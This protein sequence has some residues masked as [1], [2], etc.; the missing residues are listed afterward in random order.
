MPK[1]LRNYPI[2]IA[3]Q[4]RGYIDTT[5]RPIVFDEKTN[6]N[7]N[8]DDVNDKITIY[9]RQVK[10][11]F[12]N[13]ASKFL[14]GDNNG[15]I[16]LMLSIA[17]IEGVEQYMRGESSET[18]R[19]QRG[20]SKEF[21]REGMRRIFNLRETDEILNDFYSQVRCGLF[22]TGM[23][24]NKVIINRTFQEPINFSEQDT[25]KI[26]PKMFLSQVRIDFNAYIKSLRNPNNRTERYNFDIMFSNL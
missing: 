16:I 6:I 24:Q 14:R 3:P 26:N 25:I 5:G 20:R 2:Y 12:L 23:T 21:F 17:Y 9:E 18:T 11:W 1:Q 10:G 15:F 22:H 7:L 13:R 8:P 19:T 4:I